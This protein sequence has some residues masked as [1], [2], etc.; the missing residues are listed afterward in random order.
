MLVVLGPPVSADAVCL[1]GSGDTGDADS[2]GCVDS[3]G[4]A[5][6]CW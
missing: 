1:P 5:G 6:F 2:D 4:S 3:A